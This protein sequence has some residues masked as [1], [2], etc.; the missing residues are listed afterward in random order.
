MSL[1]QYKRILARRRR[2]EMIGRTG[3]TEALL[4]HTR[5]G[6]GLVIAAA[7]R[8]GVSELLLEV[9][10]TLFA[11]ESVIVPAYF[12][13]QSA[14]A[15]ARETARRF[16]LDVLTQFV[17]FRR[18]DPLVVHMSPGTEELARLALPQDDRFVQEAAALIASDEQDELT[19]VRSCFSLPLRA[20]AKGYRL[21]VLLDDVHNAPALFGRSE[22]AELF[23]RGESPFVLALRRRSPFNA[24]GL[25]RMSLLPLSFEDSGRLAQVS[26]ERVGIEMSD[27]VRD[28]AALRC[29]GD[30]RVLQEIVD[31][32]ALRS[33]S[34][35]S[36]RAFETV[37]TETIFG[38]SVSRMFDDLF[39]DACP[40]AS[41]RQQ[42]VL[43]FADS[44]AADRRD[45]PVEAWQKRIGL[46]ESEFE[47]V[48]QRL[49][50]EEF[51]RVSGNRVEVMRENRAL[52]DHLSVKHRLETG[53]ETRA[54]VFADVL[55]AGIK[56]APNEMADHYRR[57]SA[58]GLREVMGNFD[59]KSVPAPLLFYGMFRD[60]FKGMPADELRVQLSE[61]TDLYPLPQIVFSAHTDA[62]YRAI[63]LTS[64]RERSAVAIGFEQGDLGGENRT[65]WI[66]AEID[67]KLEASEK[68]AESWCDRLEMAAA[69]SGFLQYKL[70]LVAPEGF[71]AEALDLIARRNGIGTSRRQ[72]ELLTE[73]L[74]KGTF[75]EHTQPAEEYEIIIPM[76]DDAE[77]V[78]AH[79]LEDIARR[80]N[81]PTKEVNRIKT[82][83]VEACINASEHSKS[84][85][86]RIH[87]KFTVGSDRISITISNRGLR[88]VEKSV[89]VEPN[90]GRR[91][92][93]LKLMR[94]LMDDVRIE[95]V[96]DGTR[97]SMTKYFEAA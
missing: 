17:A 86:R 85:D 8:V 90:E 83:L 94:Q 95:H 44:L 21:A 71:S 51:V 70:W 76:T 78:A 87:Q 23:G 64:Y 68:V 36:F 29:D 9:Y 15:P 77:M 88:L 11:T 80:H 97:I 1:I 72:V 46:P 25:Q 96:D 74:A 48:L 92:W 45:V 91:G 60:Q 73:Y 10:D 65:A 22:I 19:Y 32:A 43:L 59:G 56:S 12:A 47:Y 55:S 2:E 49:N 24:V 31:A 7:P 69:V 66:A 89:A 38:G 14:D 20:A 42:L 54:A 33:Q 79:T 84:P 5:K 34:L 3:E 27:A 13:F 6:G 39:I 62:F 18:N 30:L 50:I 67:S 37:Y 35:D 26:A 93:G 41:A 4:S 53:S 63:G 57:S 75:V 16:V 58:I 52:R 40:S 81:I 82:A 28:L 61:W